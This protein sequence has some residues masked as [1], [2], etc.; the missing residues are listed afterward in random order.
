MNKRWSRTW[1]K[2]LRGAALGASVIWLSACTTIDKAS[3][4]VMDSQIQ[5]GD[6][7]N[8][9]AS[10]VSFSFFAEPDVNENYLGEGTPID[11]QVVYLK[12]DSKML[13]AD[14]DQLSLE[15]ED[16][17]GKNYIAHD[18][19][20]LIPFQYKYVERAAMEK[21]VR[22]IGVLASYADPN[23]AQWKKIIRIKNTGHHY[24]FLLQFKRDKVDFIKEVY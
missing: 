1:L 22:Y 16:S 13:A 12:D 23:T 2:V 9:K 11:F 8:Y 20:S 19:Y 6:E 21:G 15:M 3:S 17:L 24:N 10:T 4:I 7:A 18:D 14:F 5:V